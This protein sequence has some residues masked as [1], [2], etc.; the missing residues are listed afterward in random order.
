[1]CIALKLFV[2]IIIQITIVVRNNEV[3]QFHKFS[4]LSTVISSNVFNCIIIHQ[5]Q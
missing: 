2:I 4:Y 3:K 5:K 1:M